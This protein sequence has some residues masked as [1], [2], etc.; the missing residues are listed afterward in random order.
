MATTNEVR[1]ALTAAS[2]AFKAAGAETL[3]AGIEREGAAANAAPLAAS[4]NPA[5]SARRA[6]G[7]LF[8]A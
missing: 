6:P 8:I 5:P 3:C 1:D 2:R 7:R 4:T